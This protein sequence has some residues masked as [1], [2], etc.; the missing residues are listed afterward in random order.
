MQFN[1]QPPEK[2]RDRIEPELRRTAS[3]DYSEAHSLYV[4]VL[5]F[6]DIK[7]GF[8]YGAIIV[9]GRLRRVD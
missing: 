9:S 3:A 2:S 7:T 5:Q 1:R 4:T 8:R 6:V